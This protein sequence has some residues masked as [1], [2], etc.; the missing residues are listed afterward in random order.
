MSSWEFPVT[1]PIHLHARIPAGDIRVIAE[2]DAAVATVSLE[3]RGRRADQLIDETE[4]SFDGGTLSVLSPDKIRLL[5]NVSLDLVVH[6]PAG[7]SAE[8]RGASADIRC[9][10]ELGDL[11]A[12]TASGDVTAA[13]IRGAAQLHSASGD[14]RLAEAGGDV[15]VKT[16]SGDIEVRR[17]GGDLTAD[18]ASG[19]IH[20]GQVGG[21]AKARTA[22]G[23]VQ[24]GSIS[25][26]LA[27]VNTVSG[28]ISVAVPPGVGVYLDLS[29]MTGDV[30]SGLTATESGSGAGLTVHCRSI[31][32]DI[33]VR[34][35][36][37]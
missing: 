3:G 14:V 37:S 30:R 22:S 16:A 25:A 26:G 35:A 4:V 29:A 34:P 20:A 15:T 23:D 8:L 27:E 17:A 9:E 7:S 11:A 12:K 33:R 13:L 32:G 19:D 5:S 24:I 18:S 6:V 28:D 31:S 2:P 10:G 1:E 36:A 21:S